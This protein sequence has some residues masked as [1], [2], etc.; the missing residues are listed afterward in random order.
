MLSYLETFCTG[1]EIQPGCP[2]VTAGSV[3][4]HPQAT[5]KTLR[6]LLGLNK[7]KTFFSQCVVTPL[8]WGSH[9]PGLIPDQDSCV[10]KTDG[11]GHAISFLTLSPGLGAADRLDLSMSGLTVSLVFQPSS[12]SFPCSYYSRKFTKRIKREGQ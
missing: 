10:L 9:R 7:F 12:C 3:T 6:L 8:P 1:T 5:Q 2:Q 4:T 11:S